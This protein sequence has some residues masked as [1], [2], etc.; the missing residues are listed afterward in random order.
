MDRESSQKI[1]LVDVSSA[2][3]EEK[4]VTGDHANPCHPSNIEE[5]DTKLSFSSRYFEGAFEEGPV[6]HWLRH[7]VKSRKYDAAFKENTICRLEAVKGLTKQDLNEMGATFNQKFL[8]DEIQ[9]LKDVQTIEAIRKDFQSV[10][11]RSQKKLLKTHSQRTLS[12]EMLSEKM[13]SEKARDS[14][15]TDRSCSPLRTYLSKTEEEMH[16]AFDDGEVKFW[17][18]TV[19]KCPQYENA[20]IKAKLWD[21]EMLPHIDD[22]RLLEMG[23]KKRKYLL[24]KMKKLSD[25]KY[26]EHIRRKHQEKKM[27][28]KSTGETKK[29]EKQRRPSRMSSAKSWLRRRMSSH[30]NSPGHWYC[31]ISHTH[32]NPEGKLL[33]LDSHVTLKGK[34]KS[35]WLDVKMSNMSMD[36]MEEGVKNSSCVIAIITDSCV[37]SEDDPNKG[38]PEQNA[39][40]NRW[41]CQQE[42]RWAI[43]YNVPIQPVIRTEDKRKI[44]NFIKMAPDDLKFLGGINWI[45]LN[46][47]NKR[48]FDL[49]IDMVIEGVDKLVENK[50]M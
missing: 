12:E 47:G 21:L 35:S 4:S 17:L 44:G 31:F 32:R 16:E 11:M 50:D 2:K 38:G 46:R 22:N 13:L 15:N 9:K 30:L 28:T 29:D 48:Y 27:L 14:Y 49:G 8:W 3:L 26:L 43:K 5:D 34:K 37:T 19:A 33:A 23:I 10:K 6:Q 7:Y 42:L 25:D 45:D 18:T 39:Y 40:F 20:F 41:M 24:M 36:A 1:S